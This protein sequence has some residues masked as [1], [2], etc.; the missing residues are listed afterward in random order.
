MF[1]IENSSIM[2]ELRLDLL[3]PEDSKRFVSFPELDF[4]IFLCSVGI[5]R[6]TKP[7]I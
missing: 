6:E 5:N 1:A 3:L 2:T 7:V 4:R